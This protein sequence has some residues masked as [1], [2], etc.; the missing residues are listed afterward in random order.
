MT[1]RKEEWEVL[2]RFLMAVQKGEKPDNQ[3]MIAGVDAVVEKMDRL[4]AR[5]GPKSRKQYAVDAPQFSI[6]M[7]WVGGDIT[8]EQAIEYIS[9]TSFCERRTAEKHLADMKPRAETTRA[10]L[11][12]LRKKGSRTN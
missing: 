11:E 3:A 8:R 5:T 6:A 7:Q 2:K 12:G 9:E 4:K 1:K 10:F